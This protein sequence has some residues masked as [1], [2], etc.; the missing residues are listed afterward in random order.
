MAHRVFASNIASGRKDGKFNPMILYEMKERL[1][2]EMCIVSLE[3]V[4]DF[5]KLEIYPCSIEPLRMPCDIYNWLLKENIGIRLS[6]D[7]DKQG[8]LIV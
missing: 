3:T 4:Q 1:V 8:I 5:D 2:D 7:E 6:I